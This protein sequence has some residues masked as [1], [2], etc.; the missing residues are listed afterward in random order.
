MV[1]DCILFH[2]DVYDYAKMR[3]KIRPLT[4]SHIANPHKY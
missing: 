2:T 1:E 3:P 4:Y